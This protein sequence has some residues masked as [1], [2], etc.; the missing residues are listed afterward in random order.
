TDF[1]DNRTY[2]VSSQADLTFQKTARLS[3]NLGGDQFLARYRAA[4]LVGVNGLGAHG[5]LQYRLSRRST[6]GAAYTFQHFTY[7]GQFGG[8]DA[9]TVDGTYACA[10]SSRVEFSGSFGAARV[11]QKFIHSVPVN[12]IIAS[13]FNVTATT[14]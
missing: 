2:Y 13:L 11:E 10:L 7:A 9:H 3:F 12:P 4:G 5:D 1:F 8:A 6:I 14:E